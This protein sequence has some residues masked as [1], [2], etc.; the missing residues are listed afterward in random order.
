MNTGVPDKTSKCLFYLYKILVKTKPTLLRSKVASS[1]IHR[2]GLFSTTTIIVYFHVDLLARSPSRYLAYLVKKK[3]LC[4]HS[5]C[6]MISPLPK[7][8]HYLVQQ[9]IP[10]R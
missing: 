1:T 6:R 7:L 5:Q 3:K 4:L 2:N 10:T 9:V 8:P